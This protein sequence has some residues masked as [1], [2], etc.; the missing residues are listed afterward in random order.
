MKR[1]L[2]LATASLAGLLL[3]CDW[4][5]GQGYRPVELSDIPEGKSE[6]VTPSAS[7]VHGDSLS[8][9]EW[10]LEAI[11]RSARNLNNKHDVASKTSIG[12]FQ[13]D[14][15]DY[16]DLVLF[17]TGP[18]DEPIVLPDA[19]QKEYEKYLAARYALFEYNKDGSKLLVL[20][21]PDKGECLYRIWTSP[22]DV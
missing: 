20:C 21:H 22:S 8:G 6:Y 5:S 18:C 16:S 17:L 2:A 11:P 19:L 12:S 14:P 7:V 4:E 15:K 9:H 10:L 1:F 3:A 13:F